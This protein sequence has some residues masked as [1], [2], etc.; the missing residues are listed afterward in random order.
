MSAEE[1]VASL[2]NELSDK[3]RI[4]R[5]IFGGEDDSGSAKLM[6]EQFRRLAELKESL[7]SL[8]EAIKNNTSILEFPVWLQ[9]ILNHP[10]NNLKAMILRPEMQDNYIRSERPV[11]RFNHDMVYENVNGVQVE[12]KNQ[13][14]FYDESVG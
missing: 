13:S 12:T 2:M 6:D 14:L 8:V 5:S 1:E 10:G 9:K 11:C 4:L 3:M 7:P